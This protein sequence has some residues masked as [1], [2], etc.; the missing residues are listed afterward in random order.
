MA[1]KKITKKR[2]PALRVQYGCD[3]VERYLDRAINE[4]KEELLPR[5]AALDERDKKQY[6]N[7]RDYLTQSFESIITKN[8]NVEST[9]QRVGTE[10]E[11]IYE[12][13]KKMVE[14]M[15]GMFQK[16]HDMLTEHVTD[17]TAEFKAISE[18]QEAMK[19]TI[20]TVQDTLNTVSANG[21]KGL[22]ASLKDL[23]AK[24]TEVHKELI[25]IKE[26]MAPAIN[27]HMWW[28]STKSVA[29][30]T[31]FFKMGGHKIGRYILVF[32]F[33]VFF[34]TIFHTLVGVSIFDWTSLID[35]LRSLFKVG[36]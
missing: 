14:Q 10:L 15:T 28:E 27:R 8:A 2:A 11:E 17:E 23:Y 32:L 36:G 30:T 1:K 35:I 20:T 18:K 31:W 12:D 16:L 3:E 33:L 19:D 21:N 7:A 24:N 25:E 4:V 6:E 5:I 22:H 29:R 26:L 9:I 34:N 13:R